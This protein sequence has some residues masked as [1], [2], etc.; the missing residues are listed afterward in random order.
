M[1]K[2]WE[3]LA[4]LLSKYTVAD[5]ASA[6]AIIEGLA[7]VVAA[8]GAIIAVVVT[9]KIAKEQIEIAKNQNRISDR[10]V[11]IARQQNRIGLFHERSNNYNYIA[12]F[13]NCWEVFPLTYITIKDKETFVASL[14]SIYAMLV[15]DIQNVTAFPV[16]IADNNDLLSQIM[17]SWLRQDRLIFQKLDKLFELD[18]KNHLY[19][20]RV[21]KEYED[22]FMIIISG[23]MGNFD[24][25]ARLISFAAASSL[26]NSIK[27]GKDNFLSEI[28]KQL[29]L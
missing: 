29:E 3:T 18:E 19:I 8:V 23:L 16:K 27:A 10:Q 2:F 5:T 6:F 14:I 26:S 15:P 17:Y 1:F 4:T 24:S 12:A 7:T 13:L 25:N 20:K 22:F 9:K 11:D 21:I 28:E